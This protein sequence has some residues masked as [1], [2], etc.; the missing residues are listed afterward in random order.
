MFRIQ[1]G[2]LLK[3]M[4]DKLDVAPAYLSAI[5][6]GKRVPNKKLLNNIINS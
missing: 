3:D 4:A 1:H 2:E 6:N 5:E